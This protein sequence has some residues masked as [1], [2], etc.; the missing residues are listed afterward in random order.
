MVL[1]SV[2]NSCGTSGNRCATCNYKFICSKSPY[3]TTAH[4]NDNFDNL[5]KFIS[6]FYKDYQTN[7][8]S[9]T[10]VNTQI[11]QGLSAQEIKISELKTKLEDCCSELN[12]KLDKI[13]EK[14]SEKQNNMV[15]TENENDNPQVEVLDK[16]EL[17]LYGPNAEH[18]VEKKNIFG[19]TKWVKE[20]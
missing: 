11:Q 6:V 9:Q 15:N 8:E 1:N 12:T 17:E 10:A 4:I 3:C 19:K 13:L 16:N 20:K 14:L 2:Q 18:Y 5:A 7:S